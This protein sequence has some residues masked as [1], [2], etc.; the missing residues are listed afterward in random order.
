M[1]SPEEFGKVAVLL[2]GTSAEREVSLN[3][4]NAVLEGL[5]R[6]GVDAHGIDIREPADVIGLVEQGFERAF[7][8]LHGRGGEDGQ[9]QGALQ[10]LGIPYTGSG[11]MGSA[12]AMDKYRSK[13]VWKGLGMPTPPFHVLREEADLAIAAA[14]GFPLMI[15]PA[16]EGSSVGMSKV[17][18]DSQLDAAWQE[19]R[20]YDGLVIAEKW[21]TG[22]EYT[23]GVLDGEPLPMIRLETPREFYDYDAKYRSGDTG[24]HIP[25]GLDESKEAEGQD[26]A[27]QACEAIGVSGWGRVDLMMDEDGN[28]WLIEVN[29]VPGM[30][31]HSLVPMAARAKGMD[32]DELVYRILHQ[33]LE[34]R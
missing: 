7:I 27:L 8:V 16:H 30:T 26:I 6:K 33:T 24:Y 23:A 9:I 5:R 31:D 28:F 3:S 19:A 13:L 4:G 34:V 11:V 21:I 22:S 18:D 25:C 14:L 12:I 1:T 17:N 10:I 15:K 32:F 29:T 20:K 2:G